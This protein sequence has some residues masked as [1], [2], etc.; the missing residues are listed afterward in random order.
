M[1]PHSRKCIP[2]V[3]AVLGAFISQ[4]AFALPIDLGTAGPEEWGILTMCTDP[5]PEVKSSHELGGIV[6]NIGI[7]ANGKVDFSGGGAIEGDLYLGPNA[8]ESVSGGVTGTIYQ[9]AAAHATLMQASMDAFAAAAA[10][11]ALTAD[12]TYA[13]INAGA[14]FI[15]GG[16]Y[17]VE[18]L[19]IEDGSLTL[20]GSASDYYVFNISEELKL[21]K[22][23]IDLQGGLTWDNVLF[24]VE[25]TKSVSMNDGVYMTGII[26]APYASEVSLVKINSQMVGEIITCEKV[27]FA[28]GANLVNTIPEPGSIS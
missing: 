8:E 11:S 16:V 19:K 4:S 3:L 15:G 18:T 12:F 20:T 6:G 10:A 1:K 7:Q 9:D 23:V 22:G 24:N 14:S 2:A 13:D 5:D 27:R 21:H 26:L 28:S 17:D 25:T